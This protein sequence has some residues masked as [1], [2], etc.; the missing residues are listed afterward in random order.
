M[1][2]KKLNGIIE[3]YIKENVKEFL[4]VKPIV[5]EV[6]TDISE[7]KK[8]LKSKAKM[9]RGKIFSYTFILNEGMFKKVLRISVSDGGEIIKISKS[10]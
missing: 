3:N 8:Q 9:R 10:K 2:K 6:S 4:N 1:N 7:Y 5:K